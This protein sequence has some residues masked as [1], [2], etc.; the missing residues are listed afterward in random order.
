MSKAFTKD[1]AW[2]EPVIPARAPLPAGVPN[3]L[4]ARGLRLLREELA[5]LEDERRAVDDESIEEGER[6][7]RRA[8]VS[9][10]LGEL[11]QRIAGAQ[12]VDTADAPRDRVRFGAR[13]TLRNEA[14]GEPRRLQIVGVDEADAAQGRVAFVSP[15]ARAVL[16]A[17]V[18]DIVSVRTPRGEESVEIVAIEYPPD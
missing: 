11:V 17:G 10:R 1:D 3:Y 2:E 6:R 9:G 15:I 4:T 18:G 13:V 12:V 5:E 14:G 8:I 16:G 7:R